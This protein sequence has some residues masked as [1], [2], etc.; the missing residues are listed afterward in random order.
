MIYFENVETK[1]QAYFPIVLKISEIRKWKNGVWEGKELSLRLECLD[2]E[3]TE[4]VI[5]FNMKGKQDLFVPNR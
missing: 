3:Q 2:S 4:W 1:V 5:S